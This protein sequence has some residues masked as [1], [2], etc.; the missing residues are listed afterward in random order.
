[1]PQLIWGPGLTTVLRTLPPL[2]LIP[3]LASSLPTVFARALPS[4]TPTQVFLDLPTPLRGL[5]SYLAFILT[6]RVIHDYL[7]YRDMKRFGPDV[8]EAP[9]LK[10]RWPWNL[11]FIPFALRIREIGRF[12]F[13][14][15]EAGAD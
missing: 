12:I 7:R 6:R 3:I 4:S 8:V 5:L 15:K 10:M 11:D 2:I 13:L 14:R 9:R 1:M